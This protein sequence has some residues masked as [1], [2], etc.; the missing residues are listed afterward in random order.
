MGNLYRI[1]GSK[2]L[3][4]N[5]RSNSFRDVENNWFL[6]LVDLFGNSRDVF[7]SNFVDI[8]DGNGEA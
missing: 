7:Y 4:L 5:F 1:L 3:L 2:L 6:F 8:F